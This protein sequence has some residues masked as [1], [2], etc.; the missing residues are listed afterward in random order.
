[1]RVAALCLCACG[2]IGF[3][4][5]GDAAT[6]AQTGA[7]EVF[8]ISQSSTTGITDE[9]IELDPASGAIVD[10]KPLCEPCP[11]P[12]DLDSGDLTRAP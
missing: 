6:D 12:Y 11:T 3:G 1:V 7:S 10:R 2:R 5:V 9:L 4:E 8:P